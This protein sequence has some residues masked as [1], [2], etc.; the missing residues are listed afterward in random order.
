[1]PFAELMV[2]VLGYAFF[3]SLSQKHAFLELMFAL[4]GFLFVAILAMDSFVIQIPI[5]WSSY[6]NISTVNT[7]SQAQTDY[8]TEQFEYYEGELKYTE[9]STTKLIWFILPL[10][11]YLLFDSYGKYFIRRKS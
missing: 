5:G 7:T 11:I 1:M 3:Y 9:I 8:Q 2:W 4:Y 10:H 6:T